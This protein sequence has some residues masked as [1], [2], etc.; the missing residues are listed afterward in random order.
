MTKESLNKSV[1]AEPF[2]FAQ[3][4]LV[5]AQAASARG[6]S[7]WLR[8]GFDK[9]SPNG[10]VLF[11]KSALALALLALGACSLAPE[12]TRPPLPVEAQW[13]AS[14]MATPPMAAQVAGGASA[15]D[16]QTFFPDPR[17]QGL[18]AA[19][20]D[21]NR[22]MRV[23]VA[24]VAEARALHG[25]QDSARLPNVDLS[26]GRTASRLPAD[27]ARL[28][29]DAETSYYAGNLNL[30][31]FELD[32]WGRVKNLSA[33]ALANYLATD[34]ARRAFRLSLIADVADAYLGLQE[35]DERAVLARDT[36][37]SRGETRTLIALRREVGIASDLDFLQADAAYE[38]ARADVARIE[39]EQLS[40]QLLAVGEVA[41][42]HQRNTER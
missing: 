29:R 41:V 36:V 27:A 12:Y 38:T 18:I 30:L 15:V 33:A 9:L 7:S 39:L 4:R 2:D 3:D 17:L 25:I 26:L 14:P 22:D 31:S 35:L 5:E 40:L 20:L 19:A 34:E 6:A 10:G 32:F 24:R 21:H 23:A 42:V 1:R 13:P 16:W 8:T 37:R 11:S 28:P